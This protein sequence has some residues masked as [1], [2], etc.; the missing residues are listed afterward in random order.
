MRGAVYVFLM[1]DNWGTSHLMG[2]LAMP[3]LWAK[4]EMMERTGCIISSLRSRNC[5]SMC[6]GTP[7]RWW[8]AWESAEEVNESEFS[9]WHRNQT[10]STK[11]VASADS[12]RSHSRGDIVPR[13]S[14]LHLCILVSS[15][16][17][18]SVCV[19]LCECKLCDPFVAANHFPHSRSTQP[20][21]QDPRPYR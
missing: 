2:A 11:N 10:L 16:T 19:C 9:P 18:S 13:M 3:P 7:C 1:V 17:M 4:L 12:H 15:A 21:I 6:L 5:V 20:Q 8:G 14:P